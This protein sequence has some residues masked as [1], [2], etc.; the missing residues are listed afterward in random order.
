MRAVRYTTVCDRCR[1]EPPPG[2]PFETE[3]VDH[4]G[5]KY[6]MCADCAAKGWYLHVYKTPS[7]QTAVLIKNDR[8]ETASTLEQSQCPDPA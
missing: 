6:A 4:R 8:P 7:D 3:A 1:N 5:V 2:V